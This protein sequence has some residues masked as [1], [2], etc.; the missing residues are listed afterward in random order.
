[1]IRNSRNFPVFKSIKR[2]ILPL[3]TRSV[4]SLIRTQGIGDIA[5]IY[6]ETRRDGVAFHLA[7]VPDNFEAEPS[8]PFD[9]KYMQ[10]LFKIGFE[11]AKEGYPWITGPTLPD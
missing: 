8:E 11:M 5:T 4:S 3:M 6:F 10:K 2:R 9:Q 1:L 7:H